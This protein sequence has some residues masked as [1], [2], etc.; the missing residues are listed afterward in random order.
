MA[1]CE[2]L[3]Q[4]PIASGAFFHHRGVP[5]LSANLD[6][7]AAEHNLISDDSYLFDYLWPVRAKRGGKDH[8]YVGRIGVAI[9]FQTSHQPQLDDV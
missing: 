1:F 7:D 5:K 6:L 2:N 8:G 4:S 3:E 9:Y